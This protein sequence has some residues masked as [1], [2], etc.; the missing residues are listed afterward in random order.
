MVRVDLA[1][2]MSSN[3]EMKMSLRLMTCN[4]VSLALVLALVSRFKRCRS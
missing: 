2:Y 1:T 3:G 4:A